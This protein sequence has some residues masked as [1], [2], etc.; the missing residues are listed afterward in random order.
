MPQTLV[1]VES[2]AKAK[3]IGKFLGPGYKVEASMGHVRD[4]PKSQIGVD[5][6]NNYQPKYI[7]IRGKGDIIGDIKKDAKKSSKVLLATDP[8]REG[9]A[10]SWHLANILGINDSE[11]CRIEF[12]EITKNAIKNS[13][14][15]PR[16]INKDLVDAQQAR[17][18]LDRLV[19]YQISPILWRKVKWGLSAGRVQ[20]VTVKLICDREREIEAFVPEEYWSIT[21]KLAKN[22]SKGSF[23]AKFHGNKDGKIS[24]PN[25]D[26]CSRIADAVKDGDFK[27]LKVKRSEKK[28]YPSPPFTTSSLQQEAYKQLGFTTKKTMAVAQQLY[29]GIDI[30]GQG[31]VGLITYMRT[32]STHISEEAQK[33]ARSSIEKEFGKEYITDAPRQYKAKKGAQEAHEAIRPTS[34][35]R[36]PDQIKDSL[37]DDQYKL[38]KLIWDRFLSSQMSD[39]ILDAVSVGIICNDYIFKAAGSKVKF[40]GFMAIYS[41]KEDNDEENVNL[42]ELSEGEILKLKKLEPRQHFTQP[43]ARYT[44][45]TLVKTL[46][47]NGIG[48][49][50]TYAPIIS[51]VL[52]RGYIE[53]EKRL[54]KPTELGKV[55][56]EIMCQ[57]FK[58]IVNVEFTADM[59]NQLDGIE[60]GNKEWISVVDEF[61]RSFSPEL[62]QAEQE[63][64][65]INIEEEPEVTDILCDKCGRNM[66]IKKGRFGKFLACPGYPEC[67]NT[68]PLLEEL[69]VPCP[70]C[71]STLV[72]RK[73]KKGRKFYGCKNYPNCNFM[74]WDEPVKEKCPECGSRMVKKYLKAKGFSYF[75]TNESCKHEIPLKGGTNGETNE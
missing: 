12:H 22:K 8:D 58:R 39:A 11:K 17:R 43:P 24:I 71:G 26:E 68:K 33:E 30:K 16:V 37:K 62:K 73:T 60:D 19:G 10:I 54:L 61:Y 56:N 3:T 65:E 72:V 14:K 23:D 52:E 53:R 21:A 64:G 49:P 40:P 66:V 63:I 51:T 47:E 36:H 15:H 9:E 29:E 74:S 48:R 6:D 41:E 50:S 32:D 45:A 28:R 13:V 5:I 75:C 42:P 67:K 46:E 1:I 57:F 18:V 20:S 38:Y 44:E 27:V 34:S 2:P 7:T 70:Q 69:D 25:S 35:Q 59:E 55:V 4:L 31:S